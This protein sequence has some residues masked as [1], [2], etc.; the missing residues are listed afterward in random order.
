MEKTTIKMQKETNNF[1]TIIADYD[2]GTY[3]YQCFADSPLISLMHWKGIFINEIIYDTKKKTEI[4]LQ[5]EIDENHPTPLTDRVNV[6]F[7]LLEIGVKLVYIHII[8]TEPRQ[9]E[10]GGLE[11]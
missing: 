6:W 10:T 2:G 7:T 3:V 8:L 11:N 4:S 5:K 1:Y 9:S